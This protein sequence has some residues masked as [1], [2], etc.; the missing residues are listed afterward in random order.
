MNYECLVH[1]PQSEL[2]HSVP[3][4][5]RVDL[6]SACC[7]GEMEFFWIRPGL[8]VNRLEVSVSRPVTLD[9]KLPDD[10][11]L[12]AG[13]FLLDGAMIG[14]LPGIDGKLA[15]ER[16]ETLAFLPDQAEGRFEL[17]PGRPVLAVSV[18]LGRGPAAELMNGLAL[19]EP[20]R[21]FA[22]GEACPPFAMKGR[23]GPRIRAVLSEI[24]ACPYSGRL[25]EIYMEGKVLELLAVQMAEPLDGSRPL[26]GPHGSPRRPDIERLYAIREGLMERLTD[27][28]TLGELAAAAGISQKRLVREFVQTFGATPHGLLKERRLDLAR[29]LL[30]DRGLPVKE[31][32]E[33]VGFR[34]VTNFSNAFRERFGEPPGRYIRRQRGNGAATQNQAAE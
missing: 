3:P 8:A 21:A 32:A 18:L 1:D 30:V 17:Q 4:A 27:P 6:P 15:I 23:I 20:I 31:V 13:I 5:P 28:P 2:L 9:L 25:R 26:P 22:A 12:L 7:Q 24:L 14:H 10:D 34:Y 33:A 16:T 19:P 29:H 11:P